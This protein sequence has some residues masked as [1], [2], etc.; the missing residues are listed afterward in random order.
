[1]F[2]E[3]AVI[4]I[5]LLKNSFIRNAIPNYVDTFKSLGSILILNQILSE[6]GLLIFSGS[7]FY[8]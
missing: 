5:D 6:N 8:H 4:I 2:L 7:L 1:M 3:Q